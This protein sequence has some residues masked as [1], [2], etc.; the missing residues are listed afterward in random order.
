MDTTYHL[1]D[2]NDETAKRSGL[3]HVIDILKAAFP[4]LDSDSQQSVDILVKTGELITTVTELNQNHSVASL[5]VRKQSID[6]E[7]L[8]TSIR[9]VCYPREREII[10]MILNIFKAKNLYQTYVNL[11]QIMAS[12]SQSTESFEGAEYASGSNSSA[13]FGN[14]F[15]MNGN[16]DMMEMLTSML[17]PEQK[18]TFDNL[19]MMLNTMSTTTT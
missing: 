3:A 6:L 19:N 14:M 9:D 10:D 12:Q 11:S 5:S 16:P 13:N 8:L 17:T 1:T 4:H 7:A 18:S 15:G 2:N